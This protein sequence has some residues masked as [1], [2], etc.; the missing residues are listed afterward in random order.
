MK[1]SMIVWLAVGALVLI[2]IFS[3]FG[4]YNTLVSAETNVESKYSL[5]QTQLQR[6]VDLIPNLVNT[7]KGYAEFEKSTIQAIADAR[8]KL[9]GA[10]TPGEKAEAD[11]QLSGALARLLV[12]VENYPNLKADVQFTRLMDELAG[13]EN[14]IA[15]A[16]KDYNDAVTPYN[17]KISQFPTVIF[18]SMLGFEKKEFFKSA[19]GSDKVPEVKF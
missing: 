12:V 10:R 14:R 3:I 19:P 2:A 4:S 6:R 5:I 17:V 1:R 9:V 15:V 7:V 13:T 8:S 11:T 18:A 16:R